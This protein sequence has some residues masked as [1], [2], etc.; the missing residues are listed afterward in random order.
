MKSWLQI[1]FLS[2]EKLLNWYGTWLPCEEHLCA[3]MLSLWVTLRCSASSECPLTPELS[4]EHTAPKGTS[5]P[6]NQCTTTQWG[7]NL[8]WGVMP[9]KRV[10]GLSWCPHCWGWELHSGLYTDTAEVEPRAYIPHWVRAVLTQHISCSGLLSR[11]F[12]GC[13][14]AG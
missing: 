1:N 4:A 12:R 3:G 6:N 14:C 8:P 13:S 9:S 7:R 11:P 10:M 2:R 5:I